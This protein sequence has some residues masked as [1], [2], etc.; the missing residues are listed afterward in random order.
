MLGAE[1]VTKCGVSGAVVTDSGYLAQFLVNLVTSGLLAVTK[2]ELS[3]RG[4][5]FWLPHVRGPALGY[6]RPGAG[7]FWRVLMP[8]RTFFAFSRTFVPRQVL[9]FVRSAYRFDCPC[10]KA[11]NISYGYYRCRG[12]KGPARSTITAWHFTAG[13]ECKH[14]CSLL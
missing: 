5:R 1:P 2:S 3:A 4:Y 13:R 11:Y 8:R 6:Q 9:L 14:C 10:E 7:H 12:I